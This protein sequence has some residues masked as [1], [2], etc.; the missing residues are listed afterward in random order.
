V[1]V[2]MSVFQME[3]IDTFF[4]KDG[5]TVFIGPIQSEPKFIGPCVCE[6]IHA[7]EIKASLQI[8]GQ[9]RPLMPLGE[10]PPHRAI[11][12]RQAIDFAAI[13]IARSGFTI[14]S[15]H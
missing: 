1:D 9:R 5:T 7:N 14:R 13:G 2:D 11:S 4:F 10:K 15:K 3:V 12:T 8:D 6:I